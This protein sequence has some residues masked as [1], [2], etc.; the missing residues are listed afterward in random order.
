M[1]VCP[2]GGRGAL[3]QAMALWLCGLAVHSHLVPVSGTQLSVQHAREGGP[4][5]PGALWLLQE[6]EVIVRLAQARVLLWMP[7]AE[8][9]LGTFP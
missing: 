2:S 6:Y 4:F 8:E 7:P 5:P 9:Q 1:P 3:T